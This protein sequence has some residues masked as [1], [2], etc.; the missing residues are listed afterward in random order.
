MYP[1]VAMLVIAIYAGIFVVSVLACYFPW[2]LSGRYLFSMH[3]NRPWRFSLY[4]VL[5]ALAIL[6]VLNVDLPE[7]NQSVAILVPL[8]SLVVTFMGW[9]LVLLFA[10]TQVNEDIEVHT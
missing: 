5:V 4:S 1:G 7:G 6:T 9:F 8:L 3:F 10:K 2:W